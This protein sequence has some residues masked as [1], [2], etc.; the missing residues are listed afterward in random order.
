M[1]SAVRRKPGE[2]DRAALG[3]FSGADFEDV[4]NDVCRLRMVE[5]VHGNRGGI[6]IDRDVD[7]AAG[8]L[9]DSGT[10]APSAGKAVNQQF[11]VGV[12][13]QLREKCA[14]ATA[15]NSSISAR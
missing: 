9:L 8:G 6:M 12:Q 10:R 13:Q 1:K 4:G 11:L 2:P 7:L 14:Q 5:R 3:D 15:S